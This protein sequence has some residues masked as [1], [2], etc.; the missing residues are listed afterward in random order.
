VATGF[1]KRC[2]TLAPAGLVEIDG[3]EEPGLVLRQWVDASD[4]GLTLW[5]AT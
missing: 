3:K 1:K 2:S 5:V 4:E